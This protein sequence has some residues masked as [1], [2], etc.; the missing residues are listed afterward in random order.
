MLSEH[1]RRRQPSAIRI[2]GIRFAERQDGTEAIN[3][4]IGNVSLPMYPAMIERMSRLTAAG[5][6]FREGVVRYTATVGL[7]E[8]REAFLH[9]IAAS[10]LS[11]S[12]L[13]CQV[14]DGGSQGMEL[15][16]V[17]LGGPAGSTERPIMLIDAAYTNYKA[18]AER[19]GRATVSITRT[20]GTDGKF[21]LPDLGEIENTIVET[22]PAALVV[23]P[24]D[25]PTGQFIDHETMVSLARL[26]A[27]HDLWMVSDEAYRELF[28]TGQPASSI[29]AI[30]EGDAPGIGGRRISIET[31][32]KVWNACGLRIGAL[33]TDSVDFHTAAVAENTASLC[34]N[35]IG[36]YIF[37]ALAGENASDLQSWFQEQRDYYRTMMTAFTDRV[38][39]SLPDVIVSSPDASLYS[40]VDVRDY[41][42]PNFDALE[43]VLHCASEGR[44][45]L[46]GGPY[47]LLTAPMAEF[48]NIAEGEPNPGKTQMRIAY[49]ESPD[50]MALVPDLL[51]SLLGSY[52]GR[53]ARL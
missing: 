16:V 47:T 29:W 36:Q 33:V 42:G 39:E 27:R 38:S 52:V 3:V 7:D 21:T 53:E 22:K 40:V 28:Y 1:F 23:I 46:D 8:T 17:G 11:T 34:P 6:P 31:A 30:E 20:L 18:F 24:Y 32:S 15:V 35:A 51:V 37:G 43:F 49:V 5:S 25:N 48:Y 4:A 44:V 26:C 10:G 50:R 9:V 41:A 12:G 2:A 13:H 14:T 45:N 19:L